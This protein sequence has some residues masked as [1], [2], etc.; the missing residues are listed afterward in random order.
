[1]MLAKHACL[2]GA[3]LGSSSR[4]QHAAR[5]S[6]RRT[7]THYG[8]CTALV[9][10]RSWMASVY[11]LRASG[12]GWLTHL[13][14]A[15]TAHLSNPSSSF[16]SL[17]QPHAP[18]SNAVGRHA[19]RHDTRHTRPHRRPRVRPSV[20]LLQS[21]PVSTC[22]GDIADTGRSTAMLPAKWASASRAAP[23]PRSSCI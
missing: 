8:R 16:T 21:D 12:P 2:I 14:Y 5:K 10:A 9:C 7:G 15:S 13:W 1:M 19:L 17:N 6:S 20:Q 11:A 4:V 3:L 18:S 22:N 23:D